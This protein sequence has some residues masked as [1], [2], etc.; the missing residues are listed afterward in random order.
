[1]LDREKYTGPWAGLPVPWTDEDLFDEQTYR[2]DIQ[3]CCE[4]GI[5]GLY[6]GG[7]TGEFYAMS[8][9]EFQQTSRVLVEE[10]QRH[11]KPAVVGCTSTYTLGA[12]RKAEWAAEIGA[13]GI[14]VALPY[15]MEVS[16]EQVV[17]FFRDVS[18]AA[19][20]LPLSIYETTRTKKALTLAQHGAIKETLPNYLMVKANAGTIGV[21]PEGCRA[22]SEFANVFVSENLWTELGP[23]GVI[24]CCSAMVYWNPRVTL[25][26][27]GLLRDQRWDELRSAA[28]P[29]RRL[30]HFLAAQFGAKGFTDT[31]Y[32][33]LG[34]RASGFLRT[35]LRNRAPYPS[36]SL[37]DVESLR[38]WYEAEFSEMLE[39]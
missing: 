18:R 7:T 28:E 29:V 35:G 19:G 34:G 5:P 39:L 20:N 36:A 22:L 26:L 11:S 2:E 32:D 38:R 14:Q 24:G 16:E 33:R 3:R 13:D 10:C 23:C 12:A 1:M 4:V 30:H 17:P 27:W 21:D 9:E 8:F 15:W 6:S 31:A 37:E 25:A